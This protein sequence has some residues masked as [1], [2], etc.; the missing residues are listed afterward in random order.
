MVGG[1]DLF[2]RGE[3]LVEDDS[4]I[5]YGI[6]SFDWKRVDNVPG[7]RAHAAREK[8]CFE[9]RLVDLKPPLGVPI[10]DNSSKSVYAGRAVIYNFGS[11][12]EAD[13]VGILGS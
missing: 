10:E 6:A 2:G 1:E 9:L 12:K 4:E 8:D 7:R 3:S 5:F 11:L 13:V